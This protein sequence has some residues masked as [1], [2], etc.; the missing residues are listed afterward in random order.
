MQLVD[1]ARTQCLAA[2]KKQNHLKFCLRTVTSTCSANSTPRRATGRLS[3]GKNVDKTYVCNDHFMKPQRN[4]P[5][6]EFVMLNA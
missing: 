1:R 6:T 4:R 2:P 5:G 3:K